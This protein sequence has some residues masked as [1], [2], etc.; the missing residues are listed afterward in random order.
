MKLMIAIAAAAACS[1][2]WPAAH[3]EEPDQS[4]PPKASK[5]LSD[6]VR[7]GSLELPGV[8]ACHQCE[9]RPKPH[10]MSAAD[11][12]GIDRDGHP[13][14]AEFECGYSE[15]CKRVCNFMRCLEP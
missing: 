8:T 2:L 15:D 4:P 5:S 11:R 3:A 6:W 7:S 14:V 1:L 9:W 13:K 12:C 10:Q